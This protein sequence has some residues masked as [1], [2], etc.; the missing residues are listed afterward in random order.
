MTRRIRGLD[1]QVR[2]DAYVQDDALSHSHF[3]IVREGADFLVV[4]LRSSNGTWVNGQRVSAHR[5]HPNEFIRAGRSLFCFVEP[6][7]APY[8]GQAAVP[9]LAA[10]AAPP[11]LLPKAA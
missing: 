10:S 6:A 11:G 7:V 1:V 3:L 2:G 4:D 9:W 5:L 8:V